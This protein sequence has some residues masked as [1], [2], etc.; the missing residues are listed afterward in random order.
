MLALIPI[1]GPALAIATVAAWEALRLG[2]I[3]IGNPIA[4]ATA[5]LIGFGIW[6]LAF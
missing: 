6:A 5:Q 4:A 3:I 2:L 1:I